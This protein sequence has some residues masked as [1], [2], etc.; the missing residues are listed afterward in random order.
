VAESTRSAFRPGTPTAVSR[1]LLTAV[2]LA[3]LGGAVAVADPR[4]HHVPLCP[5]RSLTGL[6]CPLC[7]GLRS[8]AS[9][10]RGDVADAAGYNLL[11]IAAMPL[12]VVLWL[13]WIHR[14]RHGLS[15]TPPRWASPALLIVLAVFGVVRNLPAFSWLHSG[16]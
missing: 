6:D 13:V 11:L 9:L 5:L 1:P 12:A 16:G 10:A 15:L 4:V 14:R 7:G 3:G 8:V 2:G